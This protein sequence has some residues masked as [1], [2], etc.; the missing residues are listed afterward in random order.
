MKTIFCILFTFSSVLL[1]SQQFEIGPSLKYD[2]TNIANSKITNGRAVI[3]DALWKTNFGFSVIY[4]FKNPNETTSSAINLE[5]YN[6]KRGSK[7]EINSNNKFEIN[8]QSINL[9]YRIA[10]NLKD[11]FRWYVDLGF[12]Y[13]ILNQTDYYKGNTNELL[14][15]PKLEEP[16]V[17]KNNEVTFI[18]GLGVEKVITK[19][20]VA[21][22]GFNGDAGISK[23][24]Q[25]SGSFR[26]QSLGFG[27]GGRYII[28]LKKQ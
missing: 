8:S 26:T 15:F 28:S 20:F 24:N 18:Y 25:N 4:Y 27:I 6:G 9:S 13:N 23:L 1:F 11:N 5:Y 2:F 19:N 12:G 3:G 22:I 7:S 10:G 14:A 21:F 17:I 16:L